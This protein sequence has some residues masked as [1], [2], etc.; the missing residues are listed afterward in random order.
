MTNPNVPV[1]PIQASVPTLLKATAIAL[2]GAA[3]LLVTTVMP[4]EFG[5]DPT[6]IGKVLGLS[7][8]HASEASAASPASTVP[9]TEMAV[10][11][12]EAPFQTKEM[13]LVLQPNEG[14]EIKAAMREGDSF[15]FT[16]K[17]EGGAVNFDMHG[18]PPNAG[19]QFS[20]YWRDREQT[21]AH[22]NFIAPFDGAHGWYW[23][24]KGTQPVT[25][26]VRVSGFFEKLYRP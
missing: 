24:N 10:I 16:W 22:G 7:A 13:M 19:D 20:S 8:L 11:A 17:A 18:E 9:N 2:A 25:V 4:A 12:N 3:V 5:V 26:I 6:G 15:V 21:A 23:S 14:A 1:S